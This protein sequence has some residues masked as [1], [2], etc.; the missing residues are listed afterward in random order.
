VRDLRLLA[1]HGEARCL[2]RDSILE[3]TPMG[4]RSLAVALT[5]ALAPTLAHAG[6]TDSRIAEPFWKQKGCAHVHK[7]KK[8]YKV[9]RGL[10]RNTNPTVK[11]DRVDHW[12]TCLATRAKAHRAHELARTHRK[13]RKQAPQVYRILLLRNYAWTLGWLAST[14][15]CESGGNY[16]AVS[17][18][19]TYR[20]AYQFDYGTWAEVGGS[21]D[22][23]AAHPWEQDYRA[24]R[25]YSIAGSG[26]WPV[27]G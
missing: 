24:A 9:I 17:S 22:P 26:R 6:S 21:G 25:L 14:R 15:S 18:G 11:T 5:L 27:C 20:G 19:G 16:S 23:A 2:P 1:A 3:V 12:A 10:V 8:A 4:R 7:S 13:W